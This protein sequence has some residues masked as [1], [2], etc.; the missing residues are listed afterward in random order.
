MP[1]TA[2]TA[3]AIAH[4]SSSSRPRAGPC[5][6][7]A[8]TRVP[9]RSLRSAPAAR[10]SQPGDRVGRRRG[11]EPHRPATTRGRSWAAGCAGSRGR[12]P[13]R[14]RA[15]T[16]AASPR[17]TTVVDARAGVVLARAP[18]GAGVDRLFGAATIGMTRGS[19]RT[20][21]PASCRRWCGT[22]APS[23]GRPGG[24][25][26]P[27]AVPRSAPPPGARRRS[28]RTGTGRS[29]GRRRPAPAGRRR[30]PLTVSCASMRAVED[31]AG[32][33]ATRR[34]VDRGDVG[35]PRRAPAVPAATVVA[36]PCARRMPQLDASGGRRPARVVV[37]IDPQAG[38]AERWP[39]R[40]RATRS[41]GPA[42]PAPA[43]RARVHTCRQPRGSTPS[44]RPVDRRA[45]RRA[46]VG[47]P[48]RRRHGPSPRA[49]RRGRRSPAG[50]GRSRTARPPGG[51]R[52][53]RSGRGR[54][55]WPAPP[56]RR[57]PRRSPA[58]RRRRA[59]SPAAGRPGGARSGAARGTP[60]RAGRP[61]P[62]A[63]RA[64]TARQHAHPDQ[65]D[66][67]HDQRG[68]QQQHRPR[69]CG[70]CRPQ[71]HHGRDRRDRQHQVEREQPAPAVH[72]R[73]RVAP[74]LEHRAGQRARRRASAAATARAGERGRERPPVARSAPPACRRRGP[75][76]ASGASPPS[77]TPK[78]SGA[79]TS[80][81]AT[82]SAEREQHGARR[83]QAAQL[84]QRDLVAAGLDRAA[85]HLEQHEQAQ[86]R[87]LEHHDERRGLAPRA[88]RARRRQHRPQ[89]GAHRCGSPALA[90][91]RGN[92]RCDRSDVAP[93]P[94]ATSSRR[95]CVGDQRD[96]DVDLLRRRQVVRARGPAPSRTGRA[97]RT[98][99][100]R[101]RARRS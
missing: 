8:A 55:G 36:A 38:A 39:A 60:R 75:T 49:G 58:P 61:G 22:T 28:A 6:P 23:A 84:G 53:A 101:R 45:V 90:V 72:R 7:S 83:R 92:R 46:A 99:R 31:H 24:D 33:R 20:A 54:A 5:R 2:S 13:R 66:G 93:Q 85:D 4:T 86:R 17:G 10:P 67:E 80:S 3:A 29:R 50:R 41:V 91:R 9:T 30:S 82:G 94:G 81:S 34:A 44:S 19:R 12:R 96:V 27:R 25:R 43:A 79:A 65:R 62:G 11:P 74:L 40:C 15:R 16:A 47:R 68:G 18:C 70:V 87:E 52:R 37:E 51:P 1:P 57:T 73:R 56:P 48:R 26:A 35:V 14:C 97:A 63:A 88:C 21:A 89:L 98:P 71:R 95:T 77:A 78:P 76:P 64:P 59:A 100:R 32:E 69:L 42:R